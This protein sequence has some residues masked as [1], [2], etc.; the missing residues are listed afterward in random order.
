L[1]FAAQELLAG[2]R[3]FLAC[4]LRMYVSD[5]KKLFIRVDTQIYPIFYQTCESCVLDSV[6]DPHHVGA[7]P[8]HACYFDA[9][10]GP[11]LTFH[12]DEDPVPSFQ[13]KLKTIKKCLNRLKAHNPYV[14]ACHLQIDPDPDTDSNPAYHFDADP[15]TDPAYHFDADPDPDPA[16]QFDAD[17]SGSTTLVLEGNSIIFWYPTVPSNL[18]VILSRTDRPC[19]N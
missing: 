14:L 6:A 5:F 9:D 2:H 18:K 11:D 12:S 10:P 17:A 4:F 8:D 1:G 19:D 13:I 7:D 15:D 16:F 3:S